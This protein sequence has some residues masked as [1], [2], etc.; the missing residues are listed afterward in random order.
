MWGGFDS[1]LDQIIALAASLKGNTG[2][3]KTK[4]DQLLRE[5]EDKIRKVD[6]ERQAIEAA[7]AAANNSDERRKLQEILHQKEEEERRKVAEYDAQIHN[8]NQERERVERETESLRANSQEEKSKLTRLL[9]DLEEDAISYTRL[10]PS[11]PQL[12]DDDKSII[13]Q[14]FLS[15]AISGGGKLSF[16]DLQ[17]II[18]K[19]ETT[20]PQGNLKKLFQIVENDTKGRMS[21]I[22]VVAVA[23]DLVALV[24]DF[25]KIDTNGNGTLSRKEFREHFTKLGFTHRSAIDALFRFGDEDE[26]DDVTFH[27]FVHLSVT[28]LVLRILFSAADF[29]KNGK[30]SKDEILRILSEAAI[31]SSAIAKFDHFYTVVDKDDSKFLDFNE[32]VL[33]VLNMFAD[34]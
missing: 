24:G 32:F 34:E 6:A 10:R 20:E 3:I 27:E 18:R 1:V 14:L 5:Q 17:K 16:R 7:I 29:D 13:R 21:Y 15:N 26:S 2:D 23:N 11:K 28:L 25:R 31:P 4:F 8:A 22:T 19:Y 9:A 30:L 33:L 12:D